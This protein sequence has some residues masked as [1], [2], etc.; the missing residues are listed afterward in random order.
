M[1]LYA[2]KHV[3]RAR[4]SL[5]TKNTK[6]LGMYTQGVPRGPPKHKSKGKAPSEH[7]G[8]SLISPVISKGSSEATQ[9][10]LNS[11]D[12]REIPL[13]STLNSVMVLFTWKP[14]QVCLRSCACVFGWCLV[15]HKYIN[16]ARRIRMP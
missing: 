1:W 8:L 7:K 2:G 5:H 10:I 11:A 13:A 4:P 12:T 3:D 16:E 9:R 6:P 14:F 15:I